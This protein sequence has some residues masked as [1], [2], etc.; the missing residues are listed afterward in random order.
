MPFHVFQ[1]P[2]IINAF[3]SIRSDLC[4]CAC[5]LA[6]SCLGVSRAET[7]ESELK[8]SIKVKWDEDGKVPEPCSVVLAGHGSRTNSIVAMHKSYFAFRKMI[9]SDDMK[10]MYVLLQC[11]RQNR[12]AAHTPTHTKVYAIYHVVCVCENRHDFGP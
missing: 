3:F 12:P 10:Y 11:M 9:E 2:L 1:F 6:K 4:V 8:M 7:N 5:S